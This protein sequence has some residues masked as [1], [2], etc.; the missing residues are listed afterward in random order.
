MSKKITK[1]KIG[2]DLYKYI[3][4]DA[5][6]TL[7]EYEVFGI[8]Q[9]EEGEYY[10]II[11][12]SCNHGWS[13]EVLIKLDDEGKF[14][15]V[16]MLNDREEDP[17]YFAHQTTG[18]CEYYYLTRDEAVEVKLIQPLQKEIEEIKGN[19]KCLKEKQ[20]EKENELKRR[21]KALKLKKYK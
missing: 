6:N 21:I 7:L 11:C 8:L 5:F 12:K 19:I 9:R 14:K 20:Q 15:Y 10:K 16:C 3:E 18:E 1:L 13:C 2:Q 4:D 17:Q